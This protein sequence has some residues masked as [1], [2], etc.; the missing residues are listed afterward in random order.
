MAISN[1]DTQ[2]TDSRDPET[3]PIDAETNRETT[4][5]SAVHTKFSFDLSDDASL[6]LWCKMHE[7]PADAVVV[8][9]G[10]FKTVNGTLVNV[11]TLQK[12]VRAL[13]A[14]MLTDKIGF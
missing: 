12:K 1:C 13:S 8:L 6:M 2:H 9:A 7:R 10:H 14:A 5:T 3:E 4:V 11:R